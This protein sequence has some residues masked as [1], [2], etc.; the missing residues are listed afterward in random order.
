MSNLSGVWNCDDGGTYYISHFQ[1]SIR[2][3]GLSGDGQIY[4]GLWFCNVFSGSVSNNQITGRWADVPRG[5]THNAGTLTLAVH[6]DAAGNVTGLS[7]TA[8]TGGFGGSSWTFASAARPP[9]PE[10]FHVFDQVMKNQNAW[11]DHSLLDNLKPAKF[12]TAVIFGQVLADK[13]APHINYRQASGRTYKDFICLDNNDSPPD[14]DLNFDLQVDE[15]SLPADFW[16]DG[17]ETS[18]GVTGDNFRAKLDHGLG[19]L[20]CESIMYGRTAECGDDDHFNDPPLLPGWQEG[21]GNGVLVNGTPI[22][23]D[24]GLAPRDGSSSL[25]Q[26]IRGLPIGEATA[27]R[28]TGVLALDCGHGIEHDCNEDD[29]SYQNQEIHPVLAVD[30]IN[31]TG[32]DDLSG[33]WAD[34]SG[35]TVYVRQSGS[36]IWWLAASPALNDSRAAV[37]Q[38]TLA[39]D[40]RHISGTLASIPLGTDFQVGGNAPQALSC[41]VDA[42]RLQML[43]SDQSVFLR[44]LYDRVTIST[45]IDLNGVW[46]AGGAPGPVISTAYTSITVDMSAYNRPTAHGSILDSSTIQVTFPD[47]ATYTGKLTLPNMIRWSNG[48]AWTKEALIQVTPNHVSFGNVAVG[49]VADRSVH[50]ANV[51]PVDLVITIA[52]SPAGSAFRWPGR[53]AMTIPPGG[54]LNETVD[55]A[56]KG[57]GDASATLVVQSNA[58]GGP[59][60]VT[61]QGHGTKGVHPF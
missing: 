6:T 18:H 19:R 50:I 29:A 51:G 5:L 53:A 4:N 57:I 15:A 40:H 42:G 8:V 41:V 21:G 47:D 2:W 39:A 10:I 31:A 9:A 44:K 54:S 60:S 16:S 35:L 3:A 30:I 46:T 37:F 24:L 17:W 43:A 27:V 12:L 59:R 1:N 49:D 33:V 32:R 11:R 28:V 34:T 26:A 22:A 61:L 13:E 52:A 38:G 23:G 20:H 48:S 7:R 55:F 45:V 14:G 58:A 25:V 36:D 56:P